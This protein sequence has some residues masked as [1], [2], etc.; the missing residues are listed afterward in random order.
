MALHFMRVCLGILWSKQGLKESSLSFLP[1]RQL[2]RVRLFRGLP[3]EVS[4]FSMEASLCPPPP[5]GGPL[6]FPTGPGLGGLAGES[7]RKTG[8]RRRK[9]GEERRAIGKI[10]LQVSRDGNSAFTTG[11]LAVSG[12]IWVPNP[13]RRA[14]R[15]RPRP[16]PPRLAEDL[17]PNSSSACSH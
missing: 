6:L 10:C 4:P 8:G 7:P 9:Q 1:P 2:C 5:P 16:E 17:T 15:P 14:P 12:P 11:G 3:G 13:T